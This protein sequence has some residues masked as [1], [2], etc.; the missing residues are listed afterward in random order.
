MSKVCTILNTIFRIVWGFIYDALGFKI[1]Y[2]IVTSIQIA[3]SGTFY[4][5]AYYI[6]TYY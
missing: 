4:F 3:V 5:S 1:P 6:W 2:T